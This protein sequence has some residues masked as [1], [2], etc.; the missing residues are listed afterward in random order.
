MVRNLVL[1]DMTPK[2]VESVG[3]LSCRAIEAARRAT[4]GQFHRVMS[5]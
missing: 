1:E 5:P 2:V 3:R 4:N